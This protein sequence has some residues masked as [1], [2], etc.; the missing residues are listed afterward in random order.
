M[1]IFRLL[2]LQWNKRV[3]SK[4]LARNNS[5]I[6]FWRHGC[7]Y[8]T[9]NQCVGSFALPLAK[10][11]KGLAFFEFSF[12]KNNIYVRYL[13]VLKETYSMRF[14]ALFCGILMSRRCWT[15]V[16]VNSDS[17]VGSNNQRRKD[18]S[19]ELL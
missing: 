14:W 15:K 1:P 5:Y 3:I 7:N 4:G 18:I 8:P 6:G 11:C 13:M 19:T 2:D 9:R 17:N 12:V 10:G 16:F